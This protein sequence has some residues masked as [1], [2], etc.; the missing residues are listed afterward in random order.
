MSLCFASN[1]RRVLANIALFTRNWDRFSS[2]S[3]VTIDFGPGSPYNHCLLSPF[4]RVI[5]EFNDF[6]RE[7]DDFIREFGTFTREFDDFIR[8]FHAFTREFRLSI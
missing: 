6:I 8:E 3:C 1:L 7:F 2:I 5:R 4:R